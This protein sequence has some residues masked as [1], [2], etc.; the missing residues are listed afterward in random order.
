[1]NRHSLNIE[2][3]L[4]HQGNVAFCVRSRFE[5]V[6]FLTTKVYN[7][8]FI[9]YMIRITFLKNKILFLTLILFFGCFYNHKNHDKK[10]NLKKRYYNN[11]QLEY[12]SEILNDVLHGET[13]YWYENGYLKSRVIYKNGKLHGIKNVYYINGQKKYDVNYEYGQKH[14]YENWYYENGQIKSQKEY[15]YDQLIGNIYRWDI[16]GN[17]IF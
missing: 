17:I 9:Q 8:S 16:N 13:K 10:F 15:F 7:D 5:I 14:G 1:M 6:S 12:Q 11:G 2:G 4:V 3:V